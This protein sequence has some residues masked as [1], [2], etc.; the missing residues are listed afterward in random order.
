MTEQSV[1]DSHS[2]AAMLIVATGQ[3]GKEALTRQPKPDS[4]GRTAKKEQPRQESEERTVEAGQP[5]GD[6]QVSPTKA[7]NNQQLP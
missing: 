7:L 3:H 4:F 1:Q 5:G 6:S 2:K